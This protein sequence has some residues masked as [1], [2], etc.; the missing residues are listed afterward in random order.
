MAAAKKTP[1]PE[2]KKLPEPSY[3]AIEGFIERATA[4][5]ITQTFS[6]LREQ[7]GG[8]KGPRADQGKKVTKAVDRTE[9]LLSYLLQVREKLEADRKGRK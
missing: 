1:A 6:G 7:L 9:E 3:P 5:S 2:V 8:L 4:D